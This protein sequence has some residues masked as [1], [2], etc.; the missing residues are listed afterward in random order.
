MRDLV[1]HDLLPERKGLEQAGD[2]AVGQ[3]AVLVEAEAEDRDLLVL[4][5]QLG[6]ARQDLAHRPV[7]ALA[8]A[9]DGVDGDDG[10]RGAVAEQVGVDRVLAR[11][12][13][14]RVGGLEVAAGEVEL[15]AEVVAQQVE[16][17]PALVRVADRHVARGLDPEVDVGVEV[18]R[19]AQLDHDAARRLGAGLVG[20]LGLA[21]SGRGT[22]APRRRR[23]R[24]ASAGSCRERRSPRRPAAPRQASAWRRSPISVRCVTRWT[25]PSSSS[26]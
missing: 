15:E 12:D 11:H 4:A 18:V 19:P 5:H 3:V 6:V 23:A 22:S 25:V 8:H 1:G 24:R 16:D 7:L 10:R 14:A 13:A 17:R 20:L 21:G 9:D 2:A 26:R